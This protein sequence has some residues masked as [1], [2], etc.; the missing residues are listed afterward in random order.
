MAIL[1][2]FAQEHGFENEA[3]MISLLDSVKTRNHLDAIDIARWRETDGTKNGLLEL[4]VFIRKEMTELMGLIKDHNPKDHK[5]KNEEDE[6]FE[7]CDIC[8]KIGELASGLFITNGGHCNWD[9]IK[10]FE[11]MATCDIF[12]IERDSFGWLI[13]GI[14]YEGKIYSYG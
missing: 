14:K 9:N 13:G 5:R 4:P 10:K 1:D 11:E 8:D 7:D 3:E 12:S 2:K 6:D